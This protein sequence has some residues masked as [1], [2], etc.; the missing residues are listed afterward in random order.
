MVSIMSLKVDEERLIATLQDIGAKLESTVGDVI[1]DFSAVHR[2][3][4]AA[5]D[6]LTEFVD[7][8][9]EKSVNVVLSGVNIDVYRVLK[10]ASLTRRF[11]MVS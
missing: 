2:V 3:N 11:S 9:D 7:A 6:A 8:A 5:L 1:M 10:L 4:P